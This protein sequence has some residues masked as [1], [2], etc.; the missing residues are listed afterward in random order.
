MRRFKEMEVPRV[1]MGARHSGSE[2]E[3]LVRAAE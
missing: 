2:G 1:R 3:E